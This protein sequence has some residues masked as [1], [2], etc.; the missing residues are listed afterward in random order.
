MHCRNSFVT[1]NE[2]TVK[3]S[4]KFKLDVEFIVSKDQGTMILLQPPVN[5]GANC[6]VWILLYS[7][8]CLFRLYTHI[9]MTWENFPGFVFL[10]EKLT[11][12]PLNRFFSAKVL[13]SQGTPV[14]ASQRALQ[15]PSLSGDRGHQYPGKP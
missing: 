9:Q 13:H 11:W 4:P 2:V 8:K 12:R 6:K 3:L 1:P 10:I 15:A 5:L 7:L 14:H